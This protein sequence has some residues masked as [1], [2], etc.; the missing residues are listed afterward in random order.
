[1]SDTSR[2]IMNIH[3]NKASTDIHRKQIRPITELERSKGRSEDYW[4]KSELDKW[5]ED[6]RLGLLNWNSEE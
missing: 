2:P 6:K 1:M 5:N 4:Q 3:V